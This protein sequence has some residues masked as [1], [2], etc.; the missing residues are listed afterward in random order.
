VWMCGCVD[1]IEIYFFEVRMWVVNVALKVVVDM[2]VMSN[3]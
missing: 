1:E 2:R 3:E